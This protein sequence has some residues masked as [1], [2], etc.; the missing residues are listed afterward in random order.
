MY[1][2]SDHFFIYSCH[3]FPWYN[4]TCVQGGW[5]LAMCY[6]TRPRQAEYNNTWS[7]S[8]T[9]RYIFFT[10][11]YKGMKCFSYNIIT[12]TTQDNQTHWNDSD[13]I[14]DQWRHIWRP[15][16]DVPCNITFG[17]LII[18]CIPWCISIC[19]EETHFIIL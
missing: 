15:N 4:Q 3:A 7:I 9:E 5:K 10:I 1:R 11:P 16:F 12:Q 18:M 8:N 19:M 6:I 13:Y 14:N 2:Y 17:G